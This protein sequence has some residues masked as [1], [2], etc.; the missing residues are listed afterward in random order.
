MQSHGRQIAIFPIVLLITRAVIAS[1]PSEPQI[2]F[3]E[4]HIRPV[5]VRNCYECHS[6]G[7]K[8]IRG[9][10][11]LDSRAASR[12]GGESGPAVVPGDPEESLLLSALRHESFEMPPDKK[13]PAET[14][15]NFERWIADGAAD[16][17]D[18]GQLVERREIDLAA[19]REFW[20]FRPIQKP[21]VPQVR[22]TDWPLSAIDQFVLAR[23]ESDEPQSDAIELT[24]NPQSDAASLL[25]RAKFD[26]VGL[27]PTI[28][29]IR[30]FLA[31][32]TADAYAKWIDQWL[33]SRQ[34]G[35][36]WGRH[37]MDIVRFAE[38]SG[39]GR[40]LM[41]PHA[42][43]YRDYVIDSFADDVPFDQFIREQIA[44]D[45]LDAPDAPTKDRYITATGFLALG[46]T[47]YELQ[48]KEL[49]E[50]EV[51]DEQIDTM[52]RALLGLTLGC[53]RCHDHKFDPIPMTDYYALA[54]IFASTESVIHGN[55]SSYVE[56]TITSDPAYKSFEEA[57]RRLELLEDELKEQQAQIKQ[58]NQQLSE[59]AGNNGYVID[60]GQAKLT[61]TWKKSTHVPT[62]VGKNYLA[63][64][65]RDATATF[66][67]DVTGRGLLLISYSAAENRPQR[68]PIVIAHSNGSSTVTIN[69]RKAASIGG[70]YESL[71]EFH[72]PQQV[73]IVNRDASEG[74]V[75][76]DAIRF[77]PTQSDNHQ[78]VRTEIQQALQRIAKLS[79]DAAQSR[80]TIKQLKSDL[81]LKPIAMSV[82]D[83]NETGDTHLRIRGEI[84]NVGPVVPRG[85]IS[86]ACAAQSVD[87]SPQ[88]LDLSPGESGRLELANW[89]ASPDNPLTA[90]VIVNR[91]WY[92][93][94]GEGIVRTPDN[95]GV[96]GQSPT[97]PELLD[98]LATDFVQ[99]GWS[100][101]GLIR[102]IMRSRVY[103][104]DSHI[105][106]T[107]LRHDPDNR[108][109]T[110]ANRR[111]LDAEALRDAMLQISGQLEEFPGGLTIR[112]LAQY[113]LDYEFDTRKRSV[114][115]PRFRNSILDFFQIFDVANPNLTT[116]RR[117]V[118]VL[119]TQALFLM[120]SEFVDSQARHA[121]ERILAIDKSDVERLDTAY[122]R[123]LGRWPTAEE[124]KLMLQILGHGGEGQRTNAEQWTEVVHLL[125]GSVDFRYLH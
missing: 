43:R 92:Y 114:Y 97:H 106:D 89:I 65:E 90:R 93:L 32:P 113:D 17:R 104:L 101:K 35:Q 72:N 52:G 116:G 14:I 86:V 61:G 59:L 3:F 95:F 18:G 9:E 54:G 34:F 78:D 80:E 115:V 88:A 30:S 118:S 10:L 24:F 42:W 33:H 105:S 122:L 63:S 5:L 21:P 71:G 51:V 83:R 16:P 85:F 29:E 2:E 1:E 60:D 123:T 119:S 79:Q 111:R 25:R 67:L 75:I 74:A 27:P 49:L 4:K 121:A 77:I 81:P 46:P 53:V 39:G 62:F 44:G 8:N 58:V 108:F 73:R 109:L 22:R 7:A 125:F 68:L 26:L 50:L 20:S 69:Q 120:N 45:L 57:N 37:W 12:R 76:I 87:G 13:L 84:R 6:A 40:S 103:Q 100:I 56:R 48:D 96:M 28:K 94:M 110:H 82:R 47:N 102:N 99:S 124:R 23:L 41:F 19:G 31:A 107:A 38:S 66:E 55:V 70:L 91:V 64:S 11:L 36:R 112:K 15:A 117:P 98:Y